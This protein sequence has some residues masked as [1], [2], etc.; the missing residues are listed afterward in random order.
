MLH[1]I[2]G[3]WKLWCYLGILMKRNVFYFAMPVYLL[4]RVMLNDTLKM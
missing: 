1:H 3:E 2:S 4:V